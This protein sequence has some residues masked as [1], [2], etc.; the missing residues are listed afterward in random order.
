MADLSCPSCNS[1]ALEPGHIQSTGLIY[2]RLDNARF[3]VLEPSEIQVK[4][5]MCLDCGH[6]SLFADAEKAARLIGNPPKTT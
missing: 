6:V 3:N 1:K 4:S 2:Q 5:R